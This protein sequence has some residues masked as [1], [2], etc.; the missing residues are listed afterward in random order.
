MSD[1]AWKR[2]AML[3]IFAFAF[4]AVVLMAV[5]VSNPNAAQTI[6]GIAFTLVAIVALRAAF[7]A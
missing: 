4:G 3:I 5:R 7:R 1:A 2:I 6:A